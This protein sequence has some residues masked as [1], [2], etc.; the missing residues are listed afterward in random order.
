M[1]LSAHRYAHV[2]DEYTDSEPAKLEGA[3]LDFGGV[4][5]KTF[6]FGSLRRTGRFQ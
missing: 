6:E 2:D 3:A 1:T 4:M 5:D